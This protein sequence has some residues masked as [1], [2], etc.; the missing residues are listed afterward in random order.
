MKSILPK[1]IA[2]IMDGNRRWAKLRGLPE[3]DG[4]RKGVEALI[5][6]VEEAGNLGVKYLTVFALSTENYKSRSD[7]EIKGL[8]KLLGEGAK[9]HIP[10]LKKEGVRLNCFGDLKS[11]PI[12]TQVIIKKVTKELAGGNKGIL[13]IAINYGGRDE[14]LRAA[15][16]VA[17]KD[18]KFTEREFED[19][20]YTSGLPDPDLV[21]RTGGQKRM[22][23]FLLWQ[24]SYSE[25]YF[26]DTLWP[27]F[28]KNEL[29]KAIDDFK[30]RKRNFGS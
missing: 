30:L 19:K 13:S 27:D 11:L 22:S 26:T 18:S 21:I 20:L 2:I 29:K 6:T 16:K 14:L 24:I 9:K 25:L 7:K 23:N 10:R 8:L 5:E 3:L 4:H 1:H 12:P 17:K 15:E 28:R